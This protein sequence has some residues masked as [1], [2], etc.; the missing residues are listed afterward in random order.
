MSALWGDYKSNVELGTGTSSILLLTHNGTAVVDY[1]IRMQQNTTGTITTGIGFSGTFAKGIDFTSATPSYAAYTIAGTGGRNNPFIKIG[2][3]DDP[4]NVVLASDH[5]VPIQVNLKNTGNAGFDIAAARL[6]VDVPA[7][8]HQQLN[9][10]QVLQIRSSIASNVKSAGTFGAG[11]SIDGAVQ[12]TDGEV[13][14]GGFSIAGSGQVTNTGSNLCTVLQACNW[15]TYAGVSV[16]HVAHFFQNGTGSTVNDILKLENIIGTST[17]GLVIA[18]T[19]GTLTTG[20]SLTGTM[21]TGISIGST[22]TTAIDITAAAGRAIRVGTKGT[23]YANSTALAISSLG[24]T[25]DTD[26][27]KNYMVGVFTK[28]QGNESTSATDDLG[29]AW[30]RTRTDI[31]VTTPGGYSL[32]GIKSQLRIYSA[33]SADATTINNWAATGMLGVLEVS[34]ASTTFASGCIASAVYANVA[35]GTGS[36]IASGAVVAG[37]ASISAS[38]AMTN[39]TNAYY[40]LYIG[41]S[42]VVSF[43]AGV[44]IV[45][46]TCTTGVDIGTCTTA[47]SVGAATTAINLS[48]AANVTNLFAFN[49]AAGCVLNVDV[50]PKDVPSGGGLGADACIRV[51]IGGQDYFIPL[52]AIELS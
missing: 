6:R 24:G 49:T 15:N 41:K 48:A 30:F 16:N 37:I 43:D 26:P 27:A 12:T 22:T 8:A 23:T 1:G 28:V 47:I 40:G 29:S 35:L 42:G 39:S 34:G 33:A 14:C 5:W 45:S 2:S 31:G 38:S 10:V 20:I 17:A 25:L 19:A 4:L 18:R 21:A 51:D 11:L 13:V 7:A 52:F 32:Y 44:K 36:T 3:W 50:N 46:S 9:A